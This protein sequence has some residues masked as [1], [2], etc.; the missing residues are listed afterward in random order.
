MRYQK[1]QVER[2]YLTIIPRARIEAEG[3]WVMTRRP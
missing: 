2:A 3:E 1:L